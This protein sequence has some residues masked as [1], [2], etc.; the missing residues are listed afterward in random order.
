METDL[1][2]EGGQVA[3]GEKKDA[4]LDH[5][6]ARAGVTSAHIA[7]KAASIAGAENDF[8]FNRGMRAKAEGNSWPAT[9]M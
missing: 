9:W 7:T 8:I 6:E 1:K 4:I 3:R 2:L 5:Q